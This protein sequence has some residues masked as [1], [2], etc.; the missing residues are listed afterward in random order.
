MPI[1]ITYTLIDVFIQKHQLVCWYKDENNEDYFVKDSFKPVIYLDTFNEEFSR[2]IL[3]NQR[4][5]K[6][7]K[8]HIVKGEI[9][10]LKITFNSI[11]DFKKNFEKIEKKLE[12]VGV[13]YNADIS[14]EEMYMFENQIYPL[15]KGEDDIKKYVYSI[16][17]FKVA[18]I[19]IKNRIELNGNFFNQTEFVIEFNKFDPDIVYIAG[20][21]KELLYLSKK[22][23]KLNRYGGDY[24]PQIEGKS[25]FSYG[26]AFYRE[27]P[28]YL[29]GRLLINSR[30]FMTDDFN[31]YSI[32]EG[33]RICRMSI[34]R[35][36]SHSVGAAVTNLLI[37][38]AYTRNYLIPYNIGVYEKIKPFKQLIECDRGALTL[39]PLT[40]MHKDV[41]ELD[42]VSMYPA[43]ISKYNL[44][45]ETFRC[46]CCREKII[47]TDYHFC[48]KK[49]AIVP[50]V[51]DFL[52]DRR[53]YFKQQKDKKSK[54]KVNFIKWLLVVIFG[55]QSF[56][57]KKIGCIEVHESINAVARNSLL[58]SIKISEKNG[59]RVLHG[60][61]DSLYLTGEGDI[62]KLIEEIY[63][64]IGLPIEFKN[65]YRFMTFLP[66]VNNTH[67]PVPTSY[68]GID[69]EGKVK[70][71]GIEIRQ[72]NSPNIVKNMQKEII[73]NFNH[74]KKI[75][76]NYVKY[77]EFATIEDIAMKA[78]IGQEEYKVNC[79]QKILADRLKK[80][81][82][83]VM[84]GQTVCFFIKDFEHKLYYFLDE[85]DGNFDKR[86]YV[87][88]LKKAYK[89]LVLPFDVSYDEIDLISKGEIQMKLSHYSTINC[90]QLLE[91]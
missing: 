19:R 62:K 86:K 80:R 57:A 7:K 6:V 50:K 34:Q 11:F 74:A 27:T 91:K 47:G 39:E 5:E 85:F 68:Y 56:K 75:L 22:G 55:F 4:V 25:Y 18:Y 29:K 13:F 9:D 66:S 71:R 84:P 63:E 60:I 79:P 31:L 51:C 54:Y 61:V 78:R 37:H 44:S 87:E 10:A 8:K 70:V 20:Q 83:E 49:K 67:M 59:F 64:E 38:E 30:S 40:G 45:P 21:Q 89:R 69:Y 14:I 1:D 12:N 41:Y 65:K 33:A 81:G 88:L 42:F 16:P 52:M 32:L 82:F 53:K 76:R 26:Q 46:K 73:K 90:T 35:I 48:K 17:E 23:L 2:K 36:A 28:I 43:I 15:K 72:R 58:K 3:K 24:F 77:L